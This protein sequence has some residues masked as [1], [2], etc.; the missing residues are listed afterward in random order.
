MGKI[1][2][3]FAGQGAQTVGMGSDIADRFDSAGRLFELSPSI[4]DLCRNGPKE[5]L[6]ITVNT[7][8]ALFLTGLACA[9]ALTEKGVA[10][11]GAAGFSLG[12][13][14]AA[15]CAGLMEPPRAFAFVRLRAEAMQRCAEK[16]K[17]CMFAVLRLTASEAERVCAALPQAYPVNYNCP[18][19]TV[20]ACAESV[21]DELQKRVA[22]AGGKTVRL[23]VSGAFH[24]PL[25]DDAAERAAA[26]LENE[27]FG[28]ARIP[29]YANATGQQYANPKETL[30][31]QI[32]HPVLWQKTV[33]TMTADGFDTFV[34]LGPGKT[35]SGLIAKINADA[36]VFNVSDIQSLEK[37]V[38]GLGYA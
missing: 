34:E 31:K 3:V 20:V 15:C 37:T 24:S 11:D 26:Y 4:R 5:R 16:Q 14:T 7:Q 21:S 1:A 30:A 38:E 29:L 10:A 25:M 18:G 32:N 27:P 28:P 6:D 12:E 22:E 35:L 9:A 13:V 8:P 17:G 2:F 19:Q 36:R 23:A 33:E